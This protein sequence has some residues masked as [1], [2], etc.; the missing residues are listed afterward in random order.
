MAKTIMGYW[1]CPQCDTKGIEGLQRVCPN[2]GRPRGDETKFYMKDKKEYIDTSKVKVSDGPD[3]LCSYCDCLNSSSD[4]VCKSCGAS[5]EDSE[6]N[7]FDLKKE[8]EAKE[9]AKA[10]EELEE[11]RAE[12]KAASQ[13]KR[14]SGLFIILAVILGLVGLIAF[15]GRKKD[16]TIDSFRWSRQIEVEESA[17]EDLS[18]WTLPSDATLQYTKRE[19]HYYTQVLDHYETVAVQK[20]RQV[21]DGGHYEYDYK[22]NGNGTYEE[23]SHW[24]T[25]YTTEYYTDYEQQAVY[26][27]EPVYDTKYYYK[28]LVWHYARNV[29]TEGN[30]HEPY[31]GDTNLADNEREGDKTETYYIITQEKDK[32]KIYELDYDEWSSLKE[33]DEFKVSAFG[34]KTVE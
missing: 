3:W 25:D 1:D 2:C 15:F 11:R 12:T 14:R 27:D 26:R 24:V 13:G 10:A 17:I 33:G 31:W 34:G 21:A 6:K 23:V 7:Y 8:R 9:Q 32:K 20:S 22:D 5:R 28:Q 19:F 30:D 4:T 16:V 18:G 29:D